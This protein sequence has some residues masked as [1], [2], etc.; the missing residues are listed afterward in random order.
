MLRGVRLTLAAAAAMVFASAGQAQAQFGYGNYGGYGGYGWG[1]WGGGGGTVQG[2]I[3]RGLGVYAMGAGIYNEKTAVANSINTDTALR[4]NEYWYEAQTV[5]NHNERLR[6]NRRM[7][8][9]AGAGDAVYKRLLENPTPQDVSSGDALNAALDQ[10]SNPRIQSS[11]LRLATDKIPGNVVRQIPFVNASEAVSI[12]LDKLTNENGWPVALRD[13]KFD[14]ERQAYSEAIDNALTV[15]ENGEISAAS[16]TQVNDALTRLRAKYEANRPTDPV[17]YGE[18]E[19]YLKSLIGMTKLLERPDVE[20]I[21][22]ELKTIKET[23]LGSLLGFM[24]TFNLR[25]GR[26][27]SP[28]QR[29]AYDQIYPLIDTHRDRVVKET[30]SDDKEV[31]KADN[32]PPPPLHPGDFYKGM[33]LDHLDGKKNPSK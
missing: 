28:A 4:W 14:A 13:P 22:A 17:R 19:L 23:T 26:A 1:G 25:F 31:A 33:H 5:A 24:H 6:L 3:A 18:S 15:D 11:A 27:T 32:P 10:L 8:R 2:S 30:S 9:D 20:K 7:K 29:L 21:V 16:L 12:S